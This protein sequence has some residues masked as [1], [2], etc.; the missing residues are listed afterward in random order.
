[1]ALDFEQEVETAA[2]SSALETTYELPDGQV[3]TIV[4]ERFRAPEALFGPEVIG[5]ESGGIHMTTFN[6]IMK[7]DV[8]IRKDL[9]GNIIMVWAVVFHEHKAQYAQAADVYS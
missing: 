2:K 1:M 9:Y 5:L 7:S 8:D 6:A 4:S 3:I